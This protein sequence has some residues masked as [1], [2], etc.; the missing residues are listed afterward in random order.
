MAAT[1]WRSALTDEQA[2]SIDSI[3][4]NRHQIAHGR[5]LGLS[6]HVLDSYRKNA[7]DALTA[8]ETAFPSY[9]AV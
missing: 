2:A 9:G 3:V 5:S 6:F 1:A 7:V 8:M 4:S